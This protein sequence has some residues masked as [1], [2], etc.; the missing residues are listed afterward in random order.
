[1]KKIWNITD[2]PSKKDIATRVLIVLGKAIQP[3]RCITVQDE[4]LDGAHKVKKDVKSGLIHIGNTLPADYMAA[5][6][7][8][9]AK[10][11]KGHNRAAGTPVQPTE[12][13]IKQ[14]VDQAVDDLQDEGDV[15]DEG[16]KKKKRR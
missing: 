12:Q 3:G 8:V 10:F 7:V 6:Q 15:R 4:E 1:M 9:R 16:W 11:P 5:K 2:D 13:E 14:E